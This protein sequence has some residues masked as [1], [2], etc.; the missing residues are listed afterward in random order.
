MNIKLILLFCQLYK[1]TFDFGKMRKRK[2]NVIKLTP[3]GID[4]MNKMRRGYEEDEARKNAY[5]VSQES[6]IID[7]SPQ[8]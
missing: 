8:N 2:L 5:Y 1:A 4:A 6:R 7:F 3:D